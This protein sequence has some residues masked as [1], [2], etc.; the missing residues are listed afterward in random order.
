MAKTMEEF[1]KVLNDIRSNLDDTAKVTE[2]LESASVDYSEMS[3]ENSVLTTN[4]EKLIK[5]NDNLRNVNMDLFLKVGN[6]RS[7]ENQKTE[8]QNQETQETQDNKLSFDNLFDENGNL[9]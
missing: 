7:E 4:N 9:K 8:N 5:D 6:Q 2:L 3:K 1:Q